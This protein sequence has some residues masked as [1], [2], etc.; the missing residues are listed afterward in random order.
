MLQKYLHIKAYIYFCVVN[1]LVCN[2]TAA[3]LDGLSREIRVRV[4]ASVGSV[5]VGCRRRGV[6]H[7]GCGYDSHRFS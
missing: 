5:S 1:Q 7:S 4:P 2:V 6:L 3:V